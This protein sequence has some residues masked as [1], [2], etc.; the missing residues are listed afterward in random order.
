MLPDPDAKRR[1]VEGAD[2]TAVDQL[3]SGVEE[4]VP[5]SDDT[6]SAAARAVLGSLMVGRP[7]DTVA[8]WLERLP[9]EMFA[10]QPVL[11]FVRLAI[12][13]AVDQGLPVGPITAVE[14]AR[15]ADIS[16]PPAWRGL[17]LTEMT[18][19]AAAAPP[20]VMLAALVDVLADHHAR[21]L[22]ERAGSVLLAA[23]WR[24]DLSDVG[25]LVQRAAG[26]ALAAIHAVGRAGADDEPADNPI[27]AL[28]LVAGVGV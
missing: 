8:S 7:A 13:A 9:P 28:N 22:V 17:V 20:P 19:I 18:D 15:R 16:E 26:D 4:M 10:Q 6:T 27:S 11:G 5:R 3:G 12:G 25:W 24:G 21:R 14:A 1:P 23:A 2:G